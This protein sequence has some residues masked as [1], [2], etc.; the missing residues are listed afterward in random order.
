MLGYICVSFLVIVD[1][2]TVSVSEFPLQL[3]LLQRLL[4][5]LNTRSH[6]TQYSN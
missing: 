4:C 5:T 6:S 3:Q 2:V 1:A